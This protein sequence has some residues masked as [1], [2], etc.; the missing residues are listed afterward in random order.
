M[1]FVRI[2]QEDQFQADTFRNGAAWAVVVNIG[3]DDTEPLNY[4][5]IVGLDLMGAGAI[6]YYFHIVEAN[7]ETE[8][9]YIYWS[10]RDTAS[11][12]PSDDRVVILGALLT[13]THVLL[14]QARPERVEVVT[15]DANPPEKALVGRQGV[16]GFGLRG[17]H[18]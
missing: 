4:S 7:S 16:R 9:E 15:H 10:G 12:I 11:F 13:A 6:E 2:I 14:E 8:D 17:P 5:L 1:A 18:R 3:F